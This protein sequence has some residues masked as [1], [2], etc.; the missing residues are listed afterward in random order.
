M[1]ITSKQVSIL[2]VIHA[3]NPDGSHVDL[4]QLLDLVDYET[5]KE[6]MQFSI[7]SLVSRGLIVKGMERRRGR[8]HVIYVPT[9]L[10]EEILVGGSSNPVTLDEHSDALLQEMESIF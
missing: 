6:S 3:R 5:S 1:N 7:R 10:C 9:P 2:R 4:D 8:K